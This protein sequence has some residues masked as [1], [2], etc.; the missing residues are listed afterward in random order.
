MT[1]AQPTPMT[2]TPSTGIAMTTALF[3][4]LLLA[5]LLLGSAAHAAL[6]SHQPLV[7]TFYDYDALGRLERIMDA[8]GYQT[9]F[10]YDANGNRIRRTDALGRI[11]QYGYDPLNRLIRITQPDG[12]ITELSYDG[13]DNLVSV[14]DPQGFTTQYTY[15]G[16]DDLIRQVSPDSGTTQYSQDPNGQLSSETDARN[17]TASYTRDDLG[18]VTQIGFGDETQS[19]TYDTAAN[20]TGQLASF[21]DASGSTSYGY[22]PQGRLAQVT[23]LIGGVTL[24]SSQSYNPA[25]QLIQRTYPSGTSVSYG[26]SHGRISQIQVNGQ[27]LL[28]NIQY[29]AD[30]RV[31]G[32]T[33]ANGQTRSQPGD[34]NGRVAGISLGNQSFTYHYDAVGN[35]TQQDPGTSAQRNYGYDS[36][37]RL[38]SAAIG[39]TQYGYSY[40]LNGNRTEKRTGSAVTTH[41]HDPNSNRLLSVAGNLNGTYSYD[42]AG[43]VVNA[44]ANVYNNAGRILRSKSGAVWWDYRYNALGQRVKKTDNASNTTL[45][46]YDEQG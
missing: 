40:D 45:F 8:Q 28:N 26:W 1:L 21:S 9:T 37:G 35:L 5:G 20:G 41:T 27:L 38:T 13:R 23:R 43:N 10:A 7:S 15:N 2:R 31:L 39:T 36:V 4:P 25:G 14:K 22:D 24:S 18:R 44:G 30:G 11:T 17:K 33:W 19:F 12:G 46:V 3:R 16:F 32:W 34:G 6:P 42:A 29:S